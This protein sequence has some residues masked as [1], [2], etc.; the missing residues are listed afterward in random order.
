MALQ[1]WRLN[2]S[3]SNYKAN[4]QSKILDKTART[5]VTVRRLRKLIPSFQ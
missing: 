5:Y 2:C 4:S 3:F 1:S